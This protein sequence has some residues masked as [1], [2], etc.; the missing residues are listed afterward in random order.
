MKT[1]MAAAIALVFAGVAHS[2]SLEVH[3][4][5]R[6]PDRGAVCSAWGGDTISLPVSIE[7]APGESFRLT[8]TL[9]QVAGGLAA[10]IGQSADPGAGVLTDSARREQVLAIQ[11]PA[12]ERPARFVYEVSVFP[13]TGGV[14]ASS[15][16]A[17]IAVWPKVE[18]AERGRLVSSA[19]ETAGLRLVVFGKSESLREYLR[20]LNVDFDDGGDG[21]PER[22]SAGAVFIGDVPAKEINDLADLRGR[23]IVVCD[24]AFSWPGVYRTVAAGADVTKI[25]Q[26][27][28]L[29]LKDDP[30]AAT[31]FEKLLIE[32]ITSNATPIV[33]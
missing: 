32:V 17:D 14:P 11:I 22:D 9:F 13:G 33:P 31:Y 20:T 25:C 4:G 18:A 21:L 27:G 23:W 16:R 12:V 19:L 8:G 1:M 6:Q 3:P 30:A 28:F 10:K 29:N 24:G 5:Q 7:G 2:G 15:F 26:P